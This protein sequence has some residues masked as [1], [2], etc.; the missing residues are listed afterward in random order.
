MIF[1]VT[2]Q[3]SA[4]SLCECVWVSMYV[5]LSLCVHMYVCVWCSIMYMYCIHRILL[6][7]CH[8]LEADRHWR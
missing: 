3:S 6:K 5:C 1:T 2:N 7:H 4:I 8:S